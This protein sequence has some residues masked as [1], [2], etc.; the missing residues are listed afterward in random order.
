M[1]DFGT[2]RPTGRPYQ[3]LVLKLDGGHLTHMY[4]VSVPMI[5]SAGKVNA[6]LSA[7]RGIIFDVGHG[8]EQFPVSAMRHQARLHP[9]FDRPICTPAV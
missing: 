2:F 7:E 6:Y 5:D 9:G 3:E 8:G 1:V 4:L